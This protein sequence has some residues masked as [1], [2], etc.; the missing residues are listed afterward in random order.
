MSLSKNLDDSLC[1]FLSNIRRS[2]VAGIFGNLI[3][4]TVNF[5]LI[6]LEQQNRNNSAI[7]EL[8]NIRNYVETKVL[9]RRDNIN[10]CLKPYFALEITLVKRGEDSML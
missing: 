1:V 2:S 8:D 9:A 10:C 5:E 3:L 7:E 4:S 6:S